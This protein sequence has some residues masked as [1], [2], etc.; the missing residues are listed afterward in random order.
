[1]MALSRWRPYLEGRTF[2]LRTDHKN[3]IFLRSSGNTK[4]IRWDNKVSDLDFVVEHVAGED[5]QLADA[6]SRCGLPT[7]LELPPSRT[8]SL[9]A[10]RT[11][12]GEADI[13]SFSDDSSSSDTLVTLLATDLN[14][15]ML[16][17]MDQLEGDGPHTVSDDLVP[18]VLVT[19]HELSGH[20]GAHRMKSMLAKHNLRWD[21]MDQDIKQHKLSCPWC[22]I[23]DAP[24]NSLLSGQGE[25]K[26]I[27]DRNTTPTNRHWQIDVIGP[28][29]ISVDGYSHILIAVD[30]FTRFVTLVPMKKPITMQRCADALLEVIYR[31]GYPERLSRDGAGNLDNKLMTALC[32]KLGITDHTGTPRHPQSQGRVER[33]VRVAMDLLKKIS[34]GST[35]HWPDHLGAVAFAM[36]TVVNRITGKTPYSL[37]YGAEARTPLTHAVTPKLSLNLLLDM[38]ELDPEEYVETLAARIQTLSALAGESQ[39]KEAKKYRDSHNLKN[40]LKRR[41]F[42]PGAVVLCHFGDSK[43]KLTSSWKGPFRIISRDGD[44]YLISAVGGP[45]REYRVHVE[46]LLDFSNKRLG[47][48]ELKRISLSSNNYMVDSVLEHKMVD[49]RRYY[50]VRWDG[51]GKEDDSWEPVENLR[52]TQALKDYVSSQKKAVS[53]I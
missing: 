50:L 51:F 41:V 17:L 3:L 23:N 21:T 33:Q 38:E 48:Q 39:V 19:I 35:S 13:L 16:S 40:Q 47:P 14:K 52:G 22:T 9:G 26:A 46:R 43:N 12:D 36:N 6:L 24:R 53:R 30:V 28:L 27:D 18:E 32:G 31:H 34:R 25:M 45:A 1:M 20:F 42:A 8:D 29:P 11:L 5:N 7:S 15:A 37:T 4:V 44:V 10:I 49:G 2:T